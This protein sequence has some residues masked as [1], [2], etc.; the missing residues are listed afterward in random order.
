[1]GRVIK[2]PEVLSQEYI[3]LKEN[4]YGLD[5]EGKRKW[6]DLNLKYYSELS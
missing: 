1:M 2:R 5:A 3:K 4:N 6:F